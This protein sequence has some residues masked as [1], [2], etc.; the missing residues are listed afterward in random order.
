MEE[1]KHK[2]LSENKTES[3]NLT[4]KLNCFKN[5][6]LYWQKFQRQII[7]LAL[8]LFQRNGLKVMMLHNMRRLQKQHILM[9]LKK[10]QLKL[11]LKITRKN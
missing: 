8:K 7:F 1:K 9:V 10:W 3:S 6:K 11:Q 5:T 4:E 2:L